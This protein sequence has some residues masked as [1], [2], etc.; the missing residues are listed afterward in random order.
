MN[1]I[2]AY[3]AYVPLH[4]LDR[5]DLALLLPPLL[6]ALDAWALEANAATEAQIALETIAYLGKT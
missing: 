4:R 5:K 3:G 1:G 2:V 6:Q